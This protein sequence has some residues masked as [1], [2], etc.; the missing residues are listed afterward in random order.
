VC[1]RGIDAS[2]V[3]AGEGPLHAELA[4]QARQRG[5]GDRVR[6]VGRVD[7]NRKWRLYDTADILLF[8]STLEGFGLV[9]AEAQARGVP[10]VAASGTATA[11]A[12]DPDRS[13]LLVAP[14]P[15]AFARAVA[16]L[17][18]PERRSAMGARAR[19][20]AQRFDWDTCAAAVAEIYRGALTR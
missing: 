10:V 7:E 19:E 16:E 14:H 11:E 3:I 17:A 4:A 9:V 1:A 20:F 12:L 5:V 2:L 8:G 18:D 13:G 6:L 15:E